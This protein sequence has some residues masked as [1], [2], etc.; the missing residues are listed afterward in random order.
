M[1]PKRF[2]ALNAAA[3]AAAAFGLG[4]LVPAW[5]YYDVARAAGH[6]FGHTSLWY[7][8]WCSFKSD[9]WGNWVPGG[10]EPNHIPTVVLLALSSSV[11][12]LVYWYRVRRLV[13]DGAEDYG[14]GR[15][16]P[17]PPA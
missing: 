9:R 7:A 5:Y 11:G 10:A 17:A 8:L 2:A 13:P 14:E 4:S 3:Y 6:K 15:Q 12:P 16:G 1:R